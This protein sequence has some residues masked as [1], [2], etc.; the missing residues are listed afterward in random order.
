MQ[1]LFRN[2]FFLILLSLAAGAQ[3]ITNPGSGEAPIFSTPV[4]GLSMATSGT[5]SVITGPTTMVASGSVVSGGRYR[6]TM[7]IVETAAGSGGTCNTGSV[8]LSLGYKDNTSGV[9]YSVG[10]SAVGAWFAFSSGTGA[11]AVT[12]ISSPGS[13]T[14][15]SLQPREFNASSG[16]AITYQIFQNTNSNCTTAPVFSVVP[17]LYYLGPN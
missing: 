2:L 1:Q 8:S 3:I 12:M 17:A 5:N 16:V 6:I 15:F 14:D 4:T 10:T 9:T 13:S 11:T 7:H